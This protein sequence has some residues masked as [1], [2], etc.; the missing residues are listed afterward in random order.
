MKNARLIVALVALMLLA[1]ACGGKSAEEELLEQI[2]ESSGEDIG[3]VEINTDGDGNLNLTI[4][5]EDGESINITGSGNEDSVNINVEGEDGENLSITGGG[6]DEE[7]TITV[8]GE[9]GG[10]MTIG[11]GEIPE[12]FELPVPDGG[13]VVTSFVSG[14]DMAI[15]LIYPGAAY[16]QLVAF[17]ESQLPSGDDVFK[18]SSSFSDADGEHQGPTWIGDNF[19]VTVTDCQGMDSNE[20]DSTCVQLNQFT[21]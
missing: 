11:S 3:D 8:D 4:E 15:S 2:L 14:Q 7:F 13:D 21:S 6:D 10:T 12:G 20:Y 1:A 19:L 5:G 9:D 18:S 17:Y 16:D